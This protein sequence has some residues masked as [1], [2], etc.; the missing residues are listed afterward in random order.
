[1]FTCKKTQHDRWLYFKLV[2][3]AKFKEEDRVDQV[4]SSKT[5]KRKRRRNVRRQ[6]KKRR[7]SKNKQDQD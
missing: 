2:V 6:S 7:T 5:K 3:R 4:S 1:M